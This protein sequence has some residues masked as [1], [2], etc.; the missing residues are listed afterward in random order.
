M[1][2][3]ILFEFGEQLAIDTTN[4]IYKG[5]EIADLSDYD[6]IITSYMDKRLA[7]YRSIYITDIPSPE[8]LDLIQSHIKKILESRLNQ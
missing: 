3:F 7:D 5:S 8:N 4:S 6:L 2:E 1:K